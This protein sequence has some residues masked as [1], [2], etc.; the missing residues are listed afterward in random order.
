MKQI[1]EQ[2]HQQVKGKVLSH[3]SA[4]RDDNNNTTEVG[5]ME[6]Q[7]GQNKQKKSQW[8]QLKSHLLKSQTLLKK[9]L[10]ERDPTRNEIVDKLI[11]LQ[12]MIE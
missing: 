11:K 2:L 8:Q 1:N 6:V 4:Q 5:I 10:D 12:H 3:F 7:G 9:K